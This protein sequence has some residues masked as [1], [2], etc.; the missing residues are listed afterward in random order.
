[1]S[2]PA[3]LYCISGGRRDGDGRCGAGKAR[4][5][6]DRIARLSSRPRASIL[7]AVECCLEATWLRR[8]RQWRVCQVLKRRRQAS[9]PPPMYFGSS[10]ALAHPAADRFGHAST[11]ED[12]EEEK[13]SL[14]QSA[15]KQWRVRQESPMAAGRE[16]GTDFRANRRHAAHPFKRHE[17][18]LKRLLTALSEMRL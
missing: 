16:R 6:L 2:V 9:G 5:V 7:P 14:R 8:V 10:I 12:K 15:P 17:N 3:R 1:M 11:W 18:I 4:R 13:D